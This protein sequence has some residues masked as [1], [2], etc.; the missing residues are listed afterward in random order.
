M[1]CRDA[2]KNEAIEEVAAM[3]REQTEAYVLAF[4]N[5]MRRLRQEDGSLNTEPKLRV[6]MP[7]A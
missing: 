4:S 5:E 7:S 1:D 6:L 3:L 2:E